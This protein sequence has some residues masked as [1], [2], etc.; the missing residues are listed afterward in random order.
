[1]NEESDNLVMK[2]ENEIPSPNSQQNKEVLKAR[3]K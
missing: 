1:V 2:L 3:F